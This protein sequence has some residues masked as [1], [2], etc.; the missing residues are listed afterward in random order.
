MEIIRSVSWLTA[1]SPSDPKPGRHHKRDRST[2]PDRI[3]RSGGSLHQLP[4][5]GGE[6]LAGGPQVGLAEVTQ[7]L[8]GEALAG[9]EVL[10]VLVDVE[11]AGEQLAPGAALLEEA[12]GGEP[13]GRVVVLGELAEHQGGAVVEVDLLDLPGLVLDPDL[14]EVRDE[15]EVVDPLVV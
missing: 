15:G 6:L 13:I 10:G 12:H 7:G 9:G 2:P 14:L 1:N 8:L 3:P 11:Q 5:E 4:H